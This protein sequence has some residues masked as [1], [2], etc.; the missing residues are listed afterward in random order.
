MLVKYQRPQK[1]PTG[2]TSPSLTE[3]FTYDK[4]GNRLTETRGQNPA[5]S[6]THNSNNELTNAGS[7][8]YVYDA[9]GNTIQETRNGQITKYT[10]N[11]WDKLEKVELPGGAIA[12]YAYDPFGRRISK[13]VNG[14]TTYFLYADEGLIGEYDSAGNLKKAYGWTP[15]SIWGTNPVFML[16]N[17]NYYF[18]HND[19]LGT[20]Q[21]IT[22]ASGNMV[23]QATY[24]AFGEATVTGSV[25]S[26]LRFPG[27]YYD[28]ETG[29]HYN[30]NRYYDP[31]SGR[32]TQT[33]PI[34]FGGGD[35]N[36]Y[37]YAYGDPT[38]WIDPMGL[39]SWNEF[40]ADWALFADI[41][42]HQQYW[43]DYGGP[44][45]SLMSGLLSFSGLATVQESGETLGDPCKSTGEKIVAGAK[46][47]GV[48]V[49]WYLGIKGP[50]YSVRDDI[51]I[52]PVGHRRWNMKWEP[53]NIKAQLPHYH[54]T[55]RGPDGKVIPGGSFKWHRPWQK[56]F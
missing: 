5:V 2:A 39:Y 19:H 23:W 13:T 16:E 14:V 49:S 42:S 9:N 17:N 50:Q 31:R 18:Y 4:A 48:G 3:A 34:G 24:T 33:D 28:A 38:N 8:T 32:Y 29:K 54:R 26:N 35:E 1:C 44:I 47:V 55:I 36:L 20:P 30:W 7:V 43:K 10:Y 6:Y 27:Q 15:D 21:K 52:A 25:T 12:T 51:A 45:G 40:M 53:V 22:D 41:R 11:A 56:G 46:I 37:R